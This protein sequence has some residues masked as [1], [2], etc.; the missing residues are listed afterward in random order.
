MNKHETSFELLDFHWDGKDIH[1]KVRQQFKRGFWVTLTSKIKGEIRFHFGQKKDILDIFSP[2]DFHM[3][4][5]SGFDTD[6]LFNVL[7]QKALTFP[8][9]Q[10]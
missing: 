3:G 5:K 9:D 2:D 7:K 10:L 4:V 6:R 8:V 1:F